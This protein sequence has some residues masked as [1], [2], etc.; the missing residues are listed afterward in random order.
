MFI[1]YL[2]GYCLVTKNYSNN[3]CILIFL[4]LPINFQVEVWEVVDKGR[5]KKKPPLGL[6]LENQ[7]AP[8]AL[9][10]EYETPVLDATFLDVYKNATGVILMLDI[11]K[12]W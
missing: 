10:E 1:I 8:S 9:E 4:F 12:P 2:L 6:K 3:K 11:T 5:T 7:S